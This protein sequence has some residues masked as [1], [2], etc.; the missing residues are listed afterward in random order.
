[1]IHVCTV[2][3]L[4]NW[5]PNSDDFA[6]KNVDSV[7]SNLKETQ[8]KKLIYI[9]LF[10]MVLMYLD[11]VVVNLNEIWFLLKAIVDERTRK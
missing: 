4:D 10:F 11:S 7:Q 3:E 1:M 9:K 2:Y 6:I 5:P 8:I